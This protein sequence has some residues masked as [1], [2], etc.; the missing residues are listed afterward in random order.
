MGWVVGDHYRTLG[1]KP[2][3]RYKLRE[4]LREHQ[5]LETSFDELGD[6]KHKD[7]EPIEQQRLLMLQKYNIRVYRL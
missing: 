5:F 7:V 6:K 1:A 3:E 2:D 4:R